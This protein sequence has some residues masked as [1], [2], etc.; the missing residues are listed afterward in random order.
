MVLQILATFVGVIGT[1]GFM[2]G[3]LLDEEEYWEGI[4]SLEK[5]IEEKN[6]EQ[7]ISLTSKRKQGIKR[8][9]TTYKIINRVDKVERYIDRLFFACIEYGH[10]VREK[11]ISAETQKEELTQLIEK[12]RTVLQ[13]LENTL[14][15]EKEEQE[16]EEK[17]EDYEV[18]NQQI[19]ELEQEKE[20]WQ[21]LL[22][23]LEVKLLNL[24]EQERQIQAQVL[25]P[26][27]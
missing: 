26:T 3:F 6:K 10:L 7:T 24:Q 18:I 15:H 8:A 9:K 11:I 12:I 22:V 2:A 23:K 25:H 17:N 13:V 19:V 21:N 16:L 14:Q 5:Q 20:E 1:H 27:N 4:Q